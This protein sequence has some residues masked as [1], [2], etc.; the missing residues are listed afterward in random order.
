ML[1]HFGSEHYCPL[2]LLRVYGSSMMEELEDH[3][4]EGNEDNYN[5]DGDN[6]VPVLPPQ[7][8]ANVDNKEPNLLER[9]ADTVISLV[10]KFTGNGSDKENGTEV[11]E[12]ANNESDVRESSNTEASGQN[13]S[14]DL[15]KGKLVTLVG[16]EDL[17]ENTEEVTGEKKDHS[18]KRNESQDKSAAVN[19]SDKHRSSCKVVDAQDESTKTCLA[20]TSRE[21]FAH[22][23]ERY[24]LGRCKRRL[25]FSESAVEA[26][27]KG[28]F[29]NIENCDNCDPNKNAN[30]DETGVENRE[31]KSKVT[32]PPHEEAVHKKASDVE[33]LDEESRTSSEA[34][35]LKVSVKI[36]EPSSSDV[37]LKRE[38]TILRPV[39]SSET[40]TP[41]SRT[42]QPS[43]AL[44]TSNKNEISDDKT[45]AL[46]DTSL[47]TSMPS[48]S[49]QAA[50]ISQMLQSSELPK[51][52]ESHADVLE[53]KPI[54]DAKKGNNKQQQSFPNS[55]TSVLEQELVESTR[56]SA[57]Q[58]KVPSETKGDTSEGR[59]EDVS[60]ASDLE[61]K[62]K[63]EEHKSS[64]SSPE[65]SAPN[66]VHVLSQSSPDIDVLETKLTDKDGR[67]GTA[68]LPEELRVKD[69]KDPLENVEGTSPSKVV[70]GSSNVHVDS[71]QGASKETT[72]S[73][74]ETEAFSREKVVSSSTVIQ[75]QSVDSA[76]HPT[77]PPSVDT[78]DSPESVV[79]LPAPPVISP[80]PP[81]TADTSTSTLEVTS[82]PS[83]SSLEAAM[84]SKAQHSSST[85]SSMASMA[86]SAGLHKESIFV[87]LSNKIK[88]L[89][90][91]LNMSTLYMEQLNQR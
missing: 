26:A 66:S 84:L 88:A 11:Q 39:E 25:H 16:H 63:M 30:D 90:Q 49:T 1:S 29:K 73:V 74:S 31:S 62:E 33:N 18:N 17:N 75:S 19:V 3:E 64:V 85:S 40:Y 42:V 61:G 52:T 46:E 10:K 86:G 45:P 76:I 68:Q 36:P 55:Q 67:E 47:V 69:E 87:R 35:N 71:E 12:V 78:P 89:E 79:P 43:Q 13:G 4:I 41:S 5:P 2:S 59:E 6:E 56:K 21:I 27:A 65:I 48:N 57:Q 7:P 51:F 22:V 9:A 20:L 24:C 70:V 81:V 23:I 91:N 32:E 28:R 44:D 77:S 58:S 50:S 38:S 14:Q 15:S 80:P 37:E 53:G 60:K 34:T 82:D 54:P 83:D 72:S 8:G